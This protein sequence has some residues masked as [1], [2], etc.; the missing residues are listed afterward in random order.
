MF[1]LEMKEYF[2][3]TN[4]RRIYYNEEKEERLTALVISCVGTAL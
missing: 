2:L 4:R 1:V 3:E